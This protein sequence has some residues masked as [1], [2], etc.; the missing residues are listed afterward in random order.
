MIV[1]ATIRYRQVGRDVD[2]A[3]PCGTRSMLFAYLGYTVLRHLS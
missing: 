3:D 2:A 1:V